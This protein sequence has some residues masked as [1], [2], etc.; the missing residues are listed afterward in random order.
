MNHKPQQFHK[1]S[2]IRAQW[3]ITGANAI[4]CR[5]T[6]LRDVAAYGSD[7]TTHP[8][9]AMGSAAARSAVAVN[10]RLFKDSARCWRKR[11]TYGV[12]GTMPW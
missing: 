6:K 10:T 9:L 4:T 8:A 11:V 3:P 2:K 12:L 1:N 7:E 5:N